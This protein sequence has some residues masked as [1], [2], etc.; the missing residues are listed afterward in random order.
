MRLLDRFKKWF[1]KEEQ[2]GIINIGDLI[3]IPGRE[4]FENNIDKLNLIDRYKDEYLS[5][6]SQIKRLTTKDISCDNLIKNN[7]MYIDLILR[8]VMRDNFYDIENQSL[9]DNKIMIY[10]LE[11]YLNEIIKIEEETIERLIALSELEKGRRVPYLN[12]NT[13]KLEINNLKISLQILISQKVSIR[14]E[15]DSYL[16]HISISNEQISPRKI[17]ERRD[18]TIRYA[19]HIININDIFDDD[20]LSDNNIYKQM[21]VIA[22]LE[23]KIE[24]ELYINRPNIVDLISRANEIKCTP[25]LNYDEAKLIK[26]KLLHDLNE[27]EDKLLVYYKFGKNLVTYEDWYNFYSAKFRILT[28]DIADNYDDAYLRKLLFDNSNEEERKAYEDIIYHKIGEILSASKGIFKFLFYNITDNQY[29]NYIITTKLLSDYFKR[30]EDYHFSI[31]ALRLLLCLDSKDNF[32]RLMNRIINIHSLPDKNCFNELKRNEGDGQFIFDEKVPLST[33]LE[34]MSDEDLNNPSYYKC[35]KEIYNAVTNII[36]YFFL[37]NLE[38]YP[39]NQDIYSRIPEGLES[40][41]VYFLPEGINTILSYNKPYDYYTKKIITE[42]KEKVVVMPK[43]LRDI[44]WFEKTKGVILN[45]G[46]KIIGQTSC[47]KSATEIFDVPA[48]LEKCGLGIIDYSNIKKLRFKDYK[49]SML[50]KNPKYLANFLYGSLVCK[51]LNFKNKR[52]IEDWPYGQMRVDVDVRVMPHVLES[53]IL[54]ENGVDVRE[55]KLDNISCYTTLK[56]MRAKKTIYNADYKL[57]L[58]YVRKLN[59]LLRDMEKDEKNMDEVK[60]KKK[61]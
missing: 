21:Y 4:Y 39:I 26:N 17:E 14:N 5:I 40:K 19:S 53:I 10:K 34:V 27:L 36:P 54:E 12:R 45:D 42:S 24:E 48:S 11:I 3:Q 46:I 23:T 49:N 59:N 51:M 38:S 57:T 30:F 33:V 37:I 7:K 52:A 28:F 15:I 60:V 61:I 9:I 16:T 29:K 43:S 32:I 44:Y 50:L 6:L 58:Y 18:K 13:L 25:D 55:I 56:S 47:F 22:T 35:L 31:P 41:D 2:I 8:L 1:F 20:E